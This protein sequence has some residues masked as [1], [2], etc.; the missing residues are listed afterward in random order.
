MVVVRNVTLIQESHNLWINKMMYHDKD[1][2][3]TLIF[4]EFINILEILTF[5]IIEHLISLI[6]LPFTLKYMIE[7]LNTIKNKIESLN[8]KVI[9]I[10]SM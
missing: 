4:P 5:Q 3:K 2:P 8:I 1:M 9:E 10:L 6:D 7:F